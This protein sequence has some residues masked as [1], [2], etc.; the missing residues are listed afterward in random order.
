MRQNKTEARGCNRRL[1]LGLQ[2][3]SRSTTYTTDQTKARKGRT[4][5]WHQ[6]TVRKRR[7]TAIPTIRPTDP[8]DLRTLIRTSTYLI[9]WAISEDPQAFPRHSRAALLE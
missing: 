9:C 7:H 1:D 3:A 2:D 5:R 8:L 6:K 4:V